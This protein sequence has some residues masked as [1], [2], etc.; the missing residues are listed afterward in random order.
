MSEPA[1][2]G[3]A[4]SRAW[5]ALIRAATLLPG[6][7][8]GPLQASVG[9][10]HYEFAM[11]KNLEAAPGSAMRV[12]ELAA[13]GSSTLP[14]TSKAVSR[15]EARGLVER[16]ACP[17]DGRA[18]T[19]RLTDGGRSAIA[20]ASPAHLAQVRSLVLDRLSPAQLEHLADALEPVVEA[21]ASRP[22][23]D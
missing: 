21:L 11:L 15:L 5:V 18:I 17:G 4:E 16:A 1:A 19:V 20:A 3:A 9:L 2:L 14:R 13:A 22:P 23:F 12:G 7:L 10:I 6:A 8:D